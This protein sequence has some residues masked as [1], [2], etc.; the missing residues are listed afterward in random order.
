MEGS[1]V[2]LGIGPRDVVIGTVEMARRDTKTKESVS[3]IGLADKIISTLNLMQ[4]DLYEKA[5]VFRKEHTFSVNTYEE[6]KKLMNEDAGFVMAH[7]DGTVETEEK[8]K[9]E[10]KATIRCIPLDS[11]VENGICMVTGKP[12]ERKVLFAKAY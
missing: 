12:S 1:P 6:F 2:R 3:Q 11:P 10:T 7:W 8:I 5:K 9:N 4:K